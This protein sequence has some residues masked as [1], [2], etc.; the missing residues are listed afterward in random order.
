MPLALVS[1]YVITFLANILIGFLVLLQNRSSI[2]N[3][4]FFGLTI[5]QAFWILSLF[6]G[7]YFAYP[8]SSNLFMS[9]YFVQIAYG[10]GLL[11]MF[12]L[13]SFLYH[14][15]R[16]I[17]KFGRVKTLIYTTL[18]FSVSIL[19]S[20]TD[21]VHDEQLIKNGVYLADSYGPL[22]SIYSILLLTSLLL[23]MFITVRKV[24]SLKGLEKNKMLYVM[25]G[26]WLFGIVTITTNL[27]LPL[28]GIAIWGTL[29]LAQIS[30]T[31]T[32]LFIL[33]TFYSIYRHRFFNFSS[34]SL[35]FLRRL[36][37]YTTFLLTGY[38]LY[39]AFVYARLDSN[40]ILISGVSFLTAYIIVG[41]INR[42]I[43]E[44]MNEGL[45]TVRK[46]IRELKPVIYSCNTLKKLQ[47]TLEYSFMINLNYINAKLYIIREK[48]DNLDVN[49]YPQNRF[50][51]ALVSFRKNVLVADEV[52][53]LK[54]N[55]TNKQLFKSQMK[56]LNADICLPL[57]SE[58]TL[59]GFFILE[60]KGQ[61]NTYSR[62]EVDEI[63]GIKRE[64]EIALM[65]ILLKLNLEEENNLMKAIIDEKTKDLTKKMGEIEEL[66]KQQSDFIAVTAHEFRTPLSIALFQMEDILE[67]GKKDKK[68]SQLS[69]DLAVIN[70]SLNN[71]K[72]LTQKLFAVQQYDL[73]KV[74]LNKEAVGIKK[75]VNGI[76][77]DFSLVMK[78]KNI[79]FSF[80][81]KIKK[82][83]KINFD[84]DQ[85]R[86]VFTNLLNNSSKFTPEKGQI[87]M[88]IEE[89]GKNILIKIDDNGKGVPD[90]YKKSI[91][92]KFRTKAVGSG[93]GL[94][95]YICKKIVELHGG[96]IYAEDSDLGGASFCLT[97]PK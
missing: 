74:V 93:I 48:D 49:I 63:I 8:G 33:P 64:L 23:A 88:S 56:R 75:Y 5:F 37:L 41:V 53:F 82:E 7:Y 42:H 1:I 96:R 21:L 94:G 39:E 31:Y 71:L 61:N 14:F 28:Y 60:K 16:R 84:K 47:K 11:M 78:D 10:T 59:I 15:P 22:Y 89:K 66:L 52:D 6:L 30:P 46:T 18:M 45:R 68:S 35:F 97:L 24:I 91:F 85:L 86:Q 65:N 3:K 36:I 34:I 38:V 67:R 92:D 81:N 51:K 43:P 27:I 2:I 76:Y 79:G 12:F 83:I 20:F 95:L 72:I 50:T 70:E 26:C 4:S 19:A 90:D 69:E 17:I 32:L 58:N 25:I 87:R 54:L 62:E 13:I 40:R 77:K 80:V 44:F 55:K 73:N 29:N 57:F 9:E